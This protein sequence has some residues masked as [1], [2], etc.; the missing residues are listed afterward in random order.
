MA[1][2]KILVG[3]EFMIEYETE[4]AL[5]GFKEYVKECLSV[6]YGSADLRVKPTGK[7]QTKVLEWIPLTDSKRKPTPG[8]NYW[9]WW[10]GS[11]VDG[12][13]IIPKDKRK[14]PYW[15]NCE[16]ERTRLIGGAVTHYAEIVEP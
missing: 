11:L 2:K 3:V 6:G 4:K 13:I 15:S 14:N 16:G 5:K 12:E 7:I 8:V 10:H 1:K 9:L